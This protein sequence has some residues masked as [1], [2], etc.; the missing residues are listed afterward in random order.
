MCVVL[1]NFTFKVGQIVSNADTDGTDLDFETF[2]LDILG[3]TAPAADEA[4]VEGG[5]ITINDDGTVIPGD[6]DD[7]DEPGVPGET[8]RLTVNEDTDE[9]H[10]R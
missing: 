4:P 7:D 5:P 6:D 8:C 1:S 10:G 3:V 2:A 9:G